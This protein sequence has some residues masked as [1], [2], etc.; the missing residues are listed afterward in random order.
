MDY[1]KEF[2]SFKS[3]FYFCSIP[4]RLD[5]YKG[6]THSCLYCFSQCL[7]NR[8]YNY[9]K[10]PKS[11]KP[12][13][14]KKLLKNNEN[15]KSRYGVISSCLRHR[16]PLHFGSISDPFQPIEKIQ[17]VS[18]NILQILCDF[19]YPTVIST[20]SSLITSPEY[21][22]ILKQLPVS[23]QVS[24]STFTE[25]LAAVIEPNAPSPIERLR[26]LEKLSSL[27]I[28]T[29]VRLQPFL[30]PIEKVNDIP[31]KTISEVGV[32]HVMLEHLRIP[33][34]SS[35]ESRKRLDNA[36][37]ANMLEKYRE[38]GIR[39][40]RVNY[41]ISSESKIDNILS[42]KKETN[43]LGMSFGAADN[44]F[45]HV[46]DM[47]CCCGLPNSEEFQNYYSGNIGYSIY[48]SIRSGEISFDNVINNWQPTGSIREFLNSDCRLKEQVTP[49]DYMFAKI[50]NPNSSNSPVSFM[51]VY[52][53]EKNGYI[54][55]KEI[56]IK[57]LQCEANGR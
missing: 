10:K 34:N 46:S 20:K 22:S 35:H 23:V 21:I 52:Y 55:D 49:V 12:E 51:G 53:D 45:H 54:I 30:Y 27:G 2:I 14:L 48:K 3:I 19:N 26:M 28:W 31:L 36:I 50:Q 40:S 15:Q 11:A 57:F 56:R 7:N 8:K 33:T 5:S 6:C 24:F 32:K 9:F 4:L 18:F 25:E 42:V 13:L 1:Y 38:I 39:N 44:D 16:L 37:G 41:E 47:P 29:V 43:L 17:K